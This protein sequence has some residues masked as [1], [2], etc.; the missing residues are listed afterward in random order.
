M[1][2]DPNPDKW[3][4]ACRIRIWPLLG[5]SSD[6]DPVD[7]WARIPTPGPWGFS[8]LTVREVEESADKN[9]TR[10]LLDSVR[11]TEEKKIPPRYLSQIYIPIIISFFN[12]L[13]L[14]LIKFCL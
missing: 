4:I 2:L 5:N 9:L 1:S 10:K 13:L 6:M 14:F 8:M 11:Q 7:L 3:C 12:I